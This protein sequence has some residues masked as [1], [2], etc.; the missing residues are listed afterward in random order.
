[1]FKFLGVFGSSNSGKPFTVVFFA[2]SVRAAKSK[3]SR[4][5]YNSSNIPRCDFIR[6]FYLDDFNSEERFI[7]SYCTFGNSIGWL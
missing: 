7:S 2:R 4:L 1:M 5:Y 3:L 6:L